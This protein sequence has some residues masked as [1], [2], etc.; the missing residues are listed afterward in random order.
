MCGNTSISCTPS[1]ASSSS[2][3]TGTASD[4]GLEMACAFPEGIGQIGSSLSISIMGCPFIQ[5]LPTTISYAEPII[6]SVDYFSDN[7]SVIIFGSNFGRWPSDITVTVN[8]IIPCIDLIVS[9]PHS[10]ISCSIRDILAYRLSRDND[11]D[12]DGDDDGETMSSFRPLSILVTVGDRR[13][14]FT[15]FHPPPPTNQIDP[16][17]SNLP[18]SPSSNQLSY[19]GFLALIVVPVAVLLAY[20]AKRGSSPFSAKSRGT[21]LDRDNNTTNASSPSPQTD[22]G[23]SSVG[24]TIE[25]SEIMIPTPPSESSDFYKSPSA[26]AVV[27]GSSSSGGSQTNGPTTTATTMHNSSSYDDLTAPITPEPVQRYPAATA[28]AGGGADGSHQQDRKFNIDSASVTLLDKIGRGSSGL[29]YKGQ[30]RGIF[31]AVKQ[32][33]D[34]TDKDLAAFMDEAQLMKLLTP[35]PNVLQIYGLAQSPTGPILTTSAAAPVAAPMIVMEFMEGGSLVH[36]LLDI[37]IVISPEAKAAMIR[38]IAL[39]MHHL[40]QEGI[41]HRDLATRNI[42]V[43]NDWTVKISDFGMSRLVVPGE[44][45]DLSL[46]RTDTQVGPLKWM[47]PECIQNQLYSKKGDVWS[48]GVVVWE[49]LHRRHPYEGLTSMQAAFGVMNHTLSLHIDDGVPGLYADLMRAC[50]D[51]EPANRPH[52]KAILKLLSS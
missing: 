22:T 28:T 20:L 18:T 10:I 6:S 38:D 5:P 1:A 41:V 14:N 21:K 3:S 25:L 40:H 27:A 8:N 45:S 51:Y 36:R 24:G 37:T 15:Y 19:L 43:G 42:L 16:P 32:L 7:S 33:L 50:W 13:S 49:I 23:D 17:P 29:V 26:L 47:A 2:S 9:Q 48:F 31:V 46:Y 4:A 39:G 44:T 34:V 11:N 12:D 35:H 52:F 30:W